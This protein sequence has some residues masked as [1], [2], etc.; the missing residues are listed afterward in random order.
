MAKF[1][2]DNDGGNGDAKE[3]ASGSA[4]APA[5][6]PG[7]DSGVGSVPSGDASAASGSA[8][9][10]DSLAGSPGPK[11]RGRKPL[12]RDASGN[13]IRDGS[14]PATNAGNK[15]GMDLNG[16][17]VNDRGKVRQQIQGIHAA[18]AILTKQSVFALADAEAVQLTNAL[19]DV[20]DYHRIN[21]TEAGGHY[22]MY[23]TLIITV[24][25]VYKPRIDIIKSG[26]RVVGV[27]ESPA[28]P[29]SPGE[30]QPRRGMMDFGANIAV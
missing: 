17:R 12:P 18:V 24:F 3:P 4:S 1:S 8:R 14:D 16:F 26:G 9:D 25:G 20:L 6:G 5:I 10:A 15:A 13:I 2:F 19:C 23:M 21:L 11:K 7:Q 29:T 27:A 30:V 28:K 22:G